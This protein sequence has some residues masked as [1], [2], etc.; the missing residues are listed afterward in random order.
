MSV[1]ELTIYSPSQLPQ[2]RLPQELRRR[3]S[4]R[5][6]ALVKKGVIDRPK[7]IRVRAEGQKSYS[8]TFHLT[9]DLMYKLLDHVKRDNGRTTVKNAI[10]LMFDEGEYKASP[11][12]SIPNE[13]RKAGI[14][15]N[16]Y[17]VMKSTS[18][19]RFR[20]FTFI[21]KGNPV[22]G[23]MMY[24]AACQDLSSI[25]TRIRDHLYY[26]KK[27][28]P[29]SYQIAK[30]ITRSVKIHSQLMAY[31]QVLDSISYIR[32]DYGVNIAA[33]RKVRKLLRKWA[34]SI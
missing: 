6:T 16:R 24:A 21:G 23:E 3:I 10:N 4:V 32:S 15:P 14:H 34:S 1:N 19:L 18:P 11:K 9:K 13:C 20:Y 22:K 2:G 25:I 33:Y 5:I 12:I 17:C 27:V 30:E 8:E 28:E 29:T 26:V 31:A 7:V